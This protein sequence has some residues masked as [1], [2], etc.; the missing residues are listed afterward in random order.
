[1]SLMDRELVGLAPLDRAGPSCLLTLS[2]AP[3]GAVLELGRSD[4]GP[5]FEPFQP[6]DFVLQGLNLL[7][8][9]L[10][11]LQQRDYEWRPLLLGDIGNLQDSLW[12]I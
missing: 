10:D 4:L 8:L 3:S 7:L 5:R 12:V 2:P 11:D 1:M 9:R 6:G